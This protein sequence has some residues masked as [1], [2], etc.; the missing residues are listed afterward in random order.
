MTCGPDGA[1]ELDE[2]APDS[3]LLLE[4]PTTPATR[5]ATPPMPTTIPRFTMRSLFRCWRRSPLPRG[6]NQQRR[7]VYC[8]VAD[9]R[10]SLRV[11]THSRAL[12]TPVGEAGGVD[13][14]RLLI[15]STSSA[16]SITCK[17]QPG[18]AGAFNDILRSVQSEAGHWL[19]DV[20]GHP[21]LAKRPALSTPMP[22]TL[23]SSQVSAFCV[24]SCCDGA[25][26]IDTECVD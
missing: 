7:N 23:A 13:R 9:P 3:D 4:Q 20:H 2:L 22:L 1:A 19:C 8:L 17:S 10:T 14:R 16:S 11:D 15:R 26:S 21:G 25:Y 24:E 5:M 6:A 12:Q 18:A